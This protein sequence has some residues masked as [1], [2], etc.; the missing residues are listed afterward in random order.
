MTSQ[1][2]D[3][4]RQSAISREH[5]RTGIQFALPRTAAGAFNW[6]HEAFY[7]REPTH[8]FDLD[9]VGPPTIQI[10]TGPYERSYAL[11]GQ[12]TY[13]FTD[14][15]QLLL[16]GRVNRD[17]KTSTGTEQ[18][19][20]FPFP[21][22]SLAATVNTTK[23]TR[24]GRSA[25]PRPD[26][27]AYVSADRGYK[28]GGANPSNSVNYIFQPEEINAYEGGYKGS[29]FGR[30]LRISSAGFYLTQDMRR[31]VRSRLS[32]RHRECTRARDLWCGIGNRCA[33]WP[34]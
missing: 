10:N 28:P 32:E 17:E 20:G 29:F 11:F 8:H 19:V 27:T 34:P 1:M 6:S 4:G 23:P 22:V 31:R 30:Q 26:S 18:L 7:L 15:W 21:P 2:D 12:A 13:K 24:K 16:G 14:K 9:V 25:P 33:A 5:V 3:L